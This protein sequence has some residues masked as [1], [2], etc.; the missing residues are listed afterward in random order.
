MQRLPTQSYARAKKITKDKRRELGAVAKKFVECE[1]LTGAE[2][3]PFITPP[4]VATEAP[5][6]IN[7]PQTKKIPIGATKGETNAAAPGNPSVKL[8]GTGAEKKGA[9]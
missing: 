6:T 8:F 5:G 7:T 4:G 1:T 9:A 2:L 3:R